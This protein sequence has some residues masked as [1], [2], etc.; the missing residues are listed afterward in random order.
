M[1]VQLL[2]NLGGRE[3]FGVTGAFDCDLGVLLSFFRVGVAV[4][5]DFRIARFF[6]DFSNDG[7]AWTNESP[8]L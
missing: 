3:Y 6:A 2:V 8:G 7:S 4:H 1:F 5:L